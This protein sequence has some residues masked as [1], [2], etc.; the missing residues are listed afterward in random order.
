MRELFDDEL[1]KLHGRFVEMGLNISEQIYYSTKAFIDH[2]KK[3]AAEVIEADNNTNGEEMKLEKQALNLI[4]LQQPVAT[5]FRIIISILKASSDLERIGDHAVSIA[6]ETIRMK[7][8]P[9]IPGVEKEIGKMTDEVRDMLEK[10][11]DAYSKSDEKSAR[12]LSEQDVGVDKEYLLIRD[13][14]TKAV[15]ANSETMPASSSYLMVI[16]LLERIG[17]HIVNLAEWIVYS[18]SGKIVELNPGKAN[19]ELVNKLY[20]EEVIEEDKDKGPNKGSK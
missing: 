14:I 12:A 4:A 17:D 16:R 18:V 8:T 15:E 9:R 13:E 2:D 1:K 7:G 20:S 10:A 6:R 5:D 3:L 11:L 19:P